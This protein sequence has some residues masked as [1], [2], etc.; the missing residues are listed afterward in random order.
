MKKLTFIIISLIFTFYNGFS[1]VIEAESGTL[2]GSEKVSKPGASGGYIV[3]MKDGN[4]SFTISVKEEGFY[5]IYLF[6]AAPYGNKTNSFNVDG[7]I[8]EFTLQQNT[9]YQLI[10]VVIAQKMKAGTHSI[11][12]LKNWGWIDIDYLKLEKTDPSSR[13]NISKTLVTQNPTDH[14]AR[15]YQFL[16]DNYGKKIISGAMTLSSMDGINWLK[17]NTGKEPAL[18]GL[19]F[20]HCGRGY[21][22]YNDN[23]PV[24]DALNYYNRN[25]I[26]AFCW[27]WRDPSRKTEAFYTKDTNFDVTKIN[28]TTSV[29]YKAIITDIDYISG[30]LKKLQ[31]N[32]VPVL[33]RPLHEASGGWFWWGAKGPEPCK[34][35]YRLLY[36]RMV[37]VNGLKNLIW[38]WTS[39]QNDYD[40]YPGND[41]VDIIGRDI[42]K[43]GDHTSQILEFNKLNNDY[44]GGKMITLSE[45]GSFPDADNLVSDAA[46]WSYYMPWY[47]E[48]IW[49]AKYNP[50]SLWIKMF[51]HDYVITLDEMPNLKSYTTPVT[52]TG[53]INFDQNQA[54]VVYPIPVKKELFIDSPLRI[55]KVEIFNIYG[56][57]IKEYQ[58]GFQN[59]R[60]QISDIEPGIYLV[61]V[62]HYP[63]VKVIKN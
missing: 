28:D 2:E 42:Y 11:R 40:W 4:L 37:N 22:W 47:R 35:L 36:N 14:A 63:S 21:T 6:V 61:K 43:D 26:P 39:Q 10:K 12:I 55:G 29:E 52:G 60:L 46:G 8:I 33:W 31:N 24:N 41:V 56:S 3:A 23:E 32:D 45:T 1:Q 30:L 38:V 18:I 5:N 58:V 15:L 54:P 20:M 51:S 34:K 17:T 49:D 57:V 19:D 48:Y 13:F 53:D 44:G 25:G 16:Y 7:Q 27:H 59:A 9:S 50:L 62:D